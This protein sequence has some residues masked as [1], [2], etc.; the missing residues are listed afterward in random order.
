MRRRSFL[1]P[2]AATG[3][4]ALS[5]VCLHCTL[6]LGEFR[7]VGA[8]AGGGGEGAGGHGGGTAL[9]TLGTTMAC[10]T[11]AAKTEGV[12][13]CRAGLATCEDGGSGFG[14]CAGE[15]TPAAADDCAT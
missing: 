14:A 15:V 11:G 13:P 3:A 2:F 8:D 6:L 9:C 4:I 12:G 5:V 10:Y 1:R 7:K